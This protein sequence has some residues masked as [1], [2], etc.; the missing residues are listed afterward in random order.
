VVADERDLIRLRTNYRGEQVFLYRIKMPAAKARALLLDY[1]A[2]VNR[3]AEHP[4]WYNAL[5]HNCTTMIR[6]HVQH[7]SPRRPW[8]WR[9][10]ANGY[11]DELAY[12]RGAIDTTLPLAEL[13]ARSDITERAKAADQDPG[14]SQR[15]REGLPGER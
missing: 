6:Y 4:R 9:I 11:V 1:L 14:F 7:V 3:L 2:D 12:E 15:I 5:T 10:F 13:R 8:D